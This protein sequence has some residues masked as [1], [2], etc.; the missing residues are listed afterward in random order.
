MECFLKPFVRLAHL[1]HKHFLALVLAS[2]ALAALCPAPGRA[3]RDTEL[4]ALLLPGAM[5]RFSILPLLLALLLANAGLAIPLAELRELG[6]RPSLLLAG[7]AA[8]FLLPLACL[9]ALVPLCRS[10]HNAEEARDLLVGL[11]LVV[12]MP[13]A[14]S[15]AAWA[16]KAD[17]N[18]ALS[19]GL[20]LGSTLLSPL[21]TPATF[22]LAGRL[23]DGPGANPLHTLATSHTG[24]FLSIWVVLPALVGLAGRWLAGEVRLARARPALKLG[25]SLVLLLL[26]YANASASLPQALAAPDWDFLGLLLGAVCGLC[27]AAFASGWLVARLLHADGPQRAALLFGLGLSNNGTG[28]VLASTSLAGLPAVALAPITYN[29][30]QHLAAASVDHLLRRNGGVTD[31]RSAE[32]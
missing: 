10:W 7:L 23:A 14:G 6:R 8:N 11:A 21:T 15:S 30:V 26:L 25:A 13:V 31:R 12:A 32:A 29:L 3:L 4:G 22:H 1:V 28:L 16:Q 20:V 9:A 18:L 5:L 17:G 19:L 2:Y 24:T 27:L